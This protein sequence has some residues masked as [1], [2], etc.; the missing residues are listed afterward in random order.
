LEEN[1]PRERAMAQNGP[2]KENQ[3]FIIL[4]IMIA[5]INAETTF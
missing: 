5:K 1:R 3:A 2:K 4:A